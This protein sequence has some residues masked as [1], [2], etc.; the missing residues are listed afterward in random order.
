MEP[1]PDRD[2]RPESRTSS[3]GAVVAAV[4]IGAILL[5]VVALHIWGAMSLHG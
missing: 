4:I 5:A 1:H 2:E 3:R